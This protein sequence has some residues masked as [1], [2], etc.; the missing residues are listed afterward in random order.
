[1]LSFDSGLAIKTKMKL[2]LLPRFTNAT[3][4]RPLAANKGCFW[5][6]AEVFLIPKM[7]SQVDNSTGRLR[8]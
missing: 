2:G 4:L 6:F 3:M 7:A 8:V 1:M 5:A